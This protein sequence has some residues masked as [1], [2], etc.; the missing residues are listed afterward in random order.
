MIFYIA[1]PMK[2]KK[3]LNRPEFF[4][5]ETLLQDAGHIVLN[6]AT[7]PV[8]MPDEAYMP[9]CLAMLEQADAIYLLKGWEKSEG[10]LIEKEYAEYQKKLLIYDSEVRRVE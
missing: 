4:R 9:I 6:P 1:G 7:L 3:H 5:V 2:G 10:A 8:G